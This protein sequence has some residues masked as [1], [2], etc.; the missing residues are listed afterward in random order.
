MDIVGVKFFEN[1]LVVLEDFDLVLADAVDVPG[2]TNQGSAALGEEQKP[3]RVMFFWN[4]DVDH[5]GSLPLT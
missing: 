2:Q 3:F 4:L 1:N 5:K